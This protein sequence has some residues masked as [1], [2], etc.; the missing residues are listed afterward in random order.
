M[1]SAFV[2]AVVETDMDG[3]SDLRSVHTQRDIA[4]DAIIQWVKDKDE[5]Y[6][7]YRAKG[8]VNAGCD[9][10]TGGWIR[11]NGFEETARIMEIEVVIR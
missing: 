11:G 10:T 7:E 5:E 2:Y 8:C 4:F 6:K 9:T 1:D 3:H